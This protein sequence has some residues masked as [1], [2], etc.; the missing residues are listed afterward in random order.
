MAF[1]QAGLCEPTI[2]VACLTTGH[3][4]NPCLLFEWR[5]A[6]RAGEYNSPCCRCVRTTITHPGLSICTALD[7]KMLT[8]RQRPKLFGSCLLLVE[9]EFNSR[10][11]RRV[12][13]VWLSRKHHGQ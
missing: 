8:V 1:G 10:G 6:A 11:D 4:L 9:G 2:S 7:L 13:L 12:R 5:R 3:G